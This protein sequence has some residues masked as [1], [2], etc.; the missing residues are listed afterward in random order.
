L[1]ARESRKPRQPPFILLDHNVQA[2]AAPLLKQLA[3]F[4][5]IGEAE[6]E[7]RFRRDVADQEIHRG[8]RAFLFV[9][10]DQD[11]LRQERLP[12]DHGGIL[13]FVCPPPTWLALSAVSSTGGGQDAIC[14]DDASFV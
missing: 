10:H 9:T 13:V 11:F 12:G 3:R 5:Q 7:R 2:E 1:A 8:R 4:R 14:C 6:K